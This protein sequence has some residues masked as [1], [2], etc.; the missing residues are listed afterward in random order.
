MLIF[1]LCGKYSSYKSMIDKNNYIR[2]LEN[3]K[4]DIKPNLNCKSYG[5]YSAQY[6]IC[7]KI[8]VGQTKNSINIRW[9]QTCYKA[10]KLKKSSLK[11]SPAVGFKYFMKEITV[12]YKL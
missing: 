1:A 10:L 4:I 12:H 9:N 3:R 5:I 7:K 11:K 8:Y 2:T 6:S